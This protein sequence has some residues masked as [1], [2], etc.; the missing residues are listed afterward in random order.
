MADKKCSALAFNFPKKGKML[1]PAALYVRIFTPFSL[2]IIRGN[3]CKYSVF[4]VS[5]I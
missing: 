3:P 1:N 5:C 4:R 2:R